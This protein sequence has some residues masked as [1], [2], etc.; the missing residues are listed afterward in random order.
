LTFVGDWTID[1]E[2]EGRDGSRIGRALS[3]SAKIRLNYVGKRLILQDF[4]LLSI[5]LCVFRKAY[6]NNS[7]FWPEFL[8][9]RKYK[10]CFG[11]SDWNW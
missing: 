4:Q 3:G 10:G 7:S 9:W 11:T 1:V 6:R 5:E 2:H 8:C